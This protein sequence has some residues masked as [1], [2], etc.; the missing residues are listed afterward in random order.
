MGDVLFSAVNASRFLKIESEQALS[1]S[2]DKFVD[3]FTRV[4]EKLDKPM[5]EYTPEQLDEVWRQIKR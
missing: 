4:E 1:N 3:R 5:K 2:C